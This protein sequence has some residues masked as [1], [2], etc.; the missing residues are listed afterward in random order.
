MT[1]LGAAILESKSKVTEQNWIGA[2]WAMIDEVY[3]ITESL[4]DD[5]DNTQDPLGI[6]EMNL[7]ESDNE[8]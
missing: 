6:G 5:P 7:S 3:K 2:Y 4:E 8:D 1:Q